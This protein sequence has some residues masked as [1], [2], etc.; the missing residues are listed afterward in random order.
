VSSHRLDTPAGAWI[1]RSRVL[2]FRFNGRA[3]SGFA[4]DTLASA[5]LANGVRLTGRSFKLHRPRGIWSCGLEEPGTLVD[6]GD[7]ARYTPNV[8]ATLMPLDEGL[9][10]RS[11]NCWPSV[12]FDLGALTGLFAPLLPA[13]FYYKTFKWP[14]W[15][16]FEP[17]IRRMA[18]MGRAPTDADSDRYEEIAAECDV[19][20]VGGGIAGLAAAVAAARAGAHTMLLTSGHTSVAHSPHAPIPRWSSSP[21]R[22]GISACASCCA[23]SPS[24]TT[25]I[26]WSVRARAS[27]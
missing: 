18:G 16:T 9:T 24:A 25:T 5:L 14:N 15:K 8:R 10:A 11:V 23:R 26:T 22:P 27:V 13:G 7:G 17:A 4:G 6:V 21:H 19:L 2:N 12:G 1:D 20:V 3:L